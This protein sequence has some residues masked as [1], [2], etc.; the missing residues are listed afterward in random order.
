MG[1]DAARQAYADFVALVGGMYDS[2][3]VKDG[4]FGAMMRVALV[5]GAR[6]PRAAGRPAGRRAGCRACP[7]ACLLCVRAWP[8][9]VKPWV[10]RMPL[11]APLP[12]LR[13][14]PASLPPWRPA[15]ADGP[16]TFTFDSRAPDAGGNSSGSLAH[17]GGGSGS[18][19]NGEG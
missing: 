3:R 4:R 1:P 19:S 9:G 18:V 13:V 7:L 15:A 10:Y 16:V 12:H 8:D 2:A 5:N 17:G 14:A 11:F 6:R